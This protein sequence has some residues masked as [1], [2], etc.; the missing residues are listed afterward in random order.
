[1]VRG[2]SPHRAKPQNYAIRLHPEAELDLAEVFTWYEEQSPG[3]GGEF[4]DEAGALL[5]RI[6]RFPHSCPLLSLAQ[7]ANDLCRLS[8]W[9][10][11]PRSGG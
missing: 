4:L 3:L 10:R 2:T 6:A 11:P 5:K 1:M 8:L 9:E 7:L